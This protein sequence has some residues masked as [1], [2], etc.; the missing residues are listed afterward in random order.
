MMMPGEEGTNANGS[1]GENGEEG[2]S[3]EY[4]DE[5]ETDSLAQTGKTL[6]ATPENYKSFVKLGGKYADMVKIKR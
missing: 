3:A 2:Y 5:G 6:D 1:Y 4:E